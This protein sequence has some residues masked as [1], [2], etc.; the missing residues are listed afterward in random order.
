MYMYVFPNCR[1]GW[2]FGGAVLNWLGL[3]QVRKVEMLLLPGKK[4]WSAK[5]D[6]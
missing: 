2:G 5:R 1:L 4:M 3:A 6:Y